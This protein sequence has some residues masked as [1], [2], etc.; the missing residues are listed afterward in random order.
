V[1]ETI[2]AAPVTPRGIFHFKRSETSWVFPSTGQRRMDMGVILKQ[3][4]AAATFG[5]L[6]APVFGQA[7][8][9]A[10]L[11]QQLSNPVADLISAPVQLNFDGNIG[12]NDDGSRWTLNIQPVVPISLNDRW[13]MISRTILPVVST[14]GIPSGPGTRE[15]PGDTVESLFF[16]PNQPTAGGWIWGARAFETFLFS[17]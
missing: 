6:C 9:Q 10:D 13:N 8:S 12:A 11:A 3:V 4:V 1:S 17:K 14:D 16:T 7:A 15:G 2:N 5:G